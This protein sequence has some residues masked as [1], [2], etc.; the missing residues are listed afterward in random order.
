MFEV[1]KLNEIF[2]LKDPI[3]DTKMNKGE[4]TQSYITRIS[5]VRYQ[6]LRV[7]EALLGRELVVQTLRVLPSIWE[8]FITIIGNKN[9]LPSFDEIIGSLTQE[10]SMMIGRGRIQKHEEGE[11]ISYISH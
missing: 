9:V 8:T 7:G 1:K 11:P 3:K 5:H 10:E 4:S 6:F 2:T